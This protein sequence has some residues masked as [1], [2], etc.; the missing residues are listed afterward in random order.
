MAHAFSATTPW[1]GETPGPLNGTPEVERLEAVK[2]AMALGNEINAVADFGD[3]PIVG[4]PIEL[5]TSYP[6]NLEQL[7]A[8]E[9][10]RLGPS[11]I[12]QSWDKTDGRGSAF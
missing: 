3:Y 7:Q 5:F 2:F 6:K 1:A 10:A 12:Q 8:D 9:R 11:G 4:D